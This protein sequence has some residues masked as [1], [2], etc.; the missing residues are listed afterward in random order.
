MCF[1]FLLCSFFFC[2]FVSYE[3]FLFSDVLVVPD[4]FV[5]AVFVVSDWSG[6]MYLR[7]SNVFVI[8]AV[9]L[10]SGV[11][12]VLFGLDDICCTQYV[13]YVY[14]LHALSRTGV[15]ADTVLFA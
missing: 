3:V 8:S 15:A 13:Q 12:C 7:I 4:V 6:V 9:L 2:A 5:S 10:V 11:L 14:S 1:L